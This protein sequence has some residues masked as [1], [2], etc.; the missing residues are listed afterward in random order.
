MTGEEEEE[1]D[2]ASFSFV[3][4]R[5]P[6]AANCRVSS[7]STRMQ[8]SK[9]GVGFFF[10]FY[11]FYFFYLFYLFLIFLGKNM[12]LFFFIFIFIFFFFFN[13]LFRIF[14]FG[15]VSDHVTARGYT[16]RESRTAMHHNRDRN[17]INKW[18]GAK[19]EKTN[20]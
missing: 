7:K 19:N 15:Q 11:F 5:V 3:A 1:E 12:F 13:F 2:M 16:K 18:C 4:S 20:Y 17:G 9:Q 6:D 10:F 8:P 14:M